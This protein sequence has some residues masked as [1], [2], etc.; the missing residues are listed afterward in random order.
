[1]ANPIIKVGLDISDIKQ[2]LLEI[3]KLTNKFNVPKA[4][5]KQVSLPATA[6]K[7]L[8]DTKEKTSLTK[9]AKDAEI[10]KQATLNALTEKGIKLNRQLASGRTTDRV[11]TSKEGKVLKSD[12]DALKTGSK[13]AVAKRIGRVGNLSPREQK[14][15]DDT[16]AQ[17]LRS[18]STEGVEPSKIPAL[19]QKKAA[20]ILRSTGT[21]DDILISNRPKPA[22]EP[23]LASSGATGAISAG[24]G[25][26]KIQET[27]RVL[28]KELILR[29]KSLLEVEQTLATSEEIQKLDVEIKSLKERYA[30]NLALG[31]VRDA[32][33][34]GTQDIKKQGSQEQRAVAAGIPIQSVGPNIVAAQDK[35]QQLE[36]GLATLSG[37]QLVA[38][39]KQLLQEYEIIKANAKI[40]GDKRLEA[41][42]GDQI[43]ALK[44]RQTAAARVAE[45]PARDLNA[46]QSRDAIAKSPEG[47]A[48]VKQRAKTDFA[49]GQ[50]SRLEKAKLAGTVPKDANIESVNKNYRNANARAKRATDKLEGISEKEIIAKN[51]S[52]VKTLEEGKLNAIILGKKKGAQVL[53]DQI[54]NAKG[55]ISSQQKIE[56]EQDRANKAADKAA[57]KA[58]KIPPKTSLEKARDEVSY[59]Q[60]PRG[61]QEQRLK[62]EASDVRKASRKQA[63]AEDSNT[64]TKPLGVFGRFTSKFGLNSQKDQSASKFFGSG[65]LTSL[66]YAI[67]SMALFGAASGISKSVVEAEQFKVELNKIQE[68]VD[69]TNWSKYGSDSKTAFAEIK[70]EIINISKET[71]LQLDIVASLTQQLIGAFASET[72]GN[73]SGLEL[74]K[75]Q[76]ESATKIAIATELAPKEITD[77]LTAASLSFGRTF[78]DIGNVAVALER[79][80]GVLGRE[81]IA[82]IGDI[83]PVAKEAGFSLEEFSALAATAQQRSGKSGAALAENFGRIIPAISENKDKLLELA[84]ASDA[85]RTPEFINAVNNSDIQGTLTTIA[86]EYE[87]LNAKSKQFVVSLLGGKREAQ[88]LIPALANNEVLERLTQAAEDSSGSLETRYQKILSSLTISVKALVQQMHVLAMEFLDSG[89]TAGLQA[90]IGAAKGL[91]FSLSGALKIVGSIN[92]VLQGF[93][94]IMLTFALIVKGIGGLGKKF[95]PGS[96][97]SIRGLTGGAGRGLA[98]G[99]AS[100]GLTAAKNA[101]AAATERLTLANQALMAATFE[102]GITGQALAAIEVEATAAKEAHR[103]ATQNLTLAEGQLTAT[104]VTGAAASAPVLAAKQALALAEVEH[105]AALQAAQVAEASGAA[106]DTLVIQANARVVASTEA[107]IAAEVAYTEALNLSGAAQVKGAATATLAAPTAASRGAAVGSGFLR[108]IGGGSVG[109]GAGVAVAAIFASVWYGLSKKADSLAEEAKEIAKIEQEATKKILESFKGNPVELAAA[110]ETRIDVLKELKRKAKSKEGIVSQ[111]VSGAKGIFGDAPSSEAQLIQD[112]IN[113]LSVSPQKALAIKLLK[114]GN[115]AYNINTFKPELGKPTGDF[116]FKIKELIAVSGNR[117]NDGVKDFEK[118]GDTKILNRNTISTSFDKEEKAYL[119]KLADFLGLNDPSELT[120]QI[121]K[122]ALQDR[123]DFIQQVTS[124]ADTGLLIGKDGKKG[125]RVDDKGTI[126][127]AN[128]II[129][130]FESRQAGGASQGDINQ[131]IEVEYQKIFGKAASVKADATLTELKSL[132]DSGGISRNQFI[133]GYLIQIENFKDVVKKGGSVDDKFLATLREAQKTVSEEVSKTVSSQ[134]S[135]AKRS[136]S[137]SGNNDIKRQQQILKSIVSGLGTDNI[138]ADLAGE[139]A[140]EYVDIQKSIMDTRIKNAYTAQQAVD[141]ANSRIDIPVS[142]QLG[143]LKSSL[144][145][146]TGSYEAFNLAF[147]A[148]SGETADMFLES[149]LNQIDSGQITVKQ[150]RDQLIEKMNVLAIEKARL[151]TLAPAGTDPADLA[152]S[153]NPVD[154][155]AAPDIPTPGNLKDPKNGLERMINGVLYRYN[156]KSRKWEI[157]SK[158]S[159]QT[160]RTSGMFSTPGKVVDYESKQAITSKD[161]AALGLPDPRPTNRRSAKPAKT[162]TAGPAPSASVRTPAEEAALANITLVIETI[163]QALGLD[164]FAKDAKDAANAATI[165]A[166]EATK[167]EAIKNLQ[168]ERQAQ[169]GLFAAMQTFN[170]DIVASAETNVIAAQEAVANA[171]NVSELAAAQSSL[172]SAQKALEDANNIQREAQFALFSAIIAK[173]DPIAQANISLV[174]AKQQATEARG[175]AAQADAARRVIEIQ[176]ELTDAMNAARISQFDLRQAELTA[177]GDEVGAAQVAAQSTRQQL[178]DTIAAGAGVAAINQARAATISADKAARDAV[179]S[180]KMDDYKFLL[181]MGQIT[182]SQY[183]NYL[184]GLKTT[185]I[186]GTKQFKD[187][188]L[189]IKQL[190]NDIGSDLQQNLP[191]SL[192]LPTLYEVRRLDQVSQTRDAAGRAGIGY[193]D[194]RTQDIKIYVN[195]GMGESEVVE[196]LSQALGTG[197][198]G[199]GPRRY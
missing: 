10:E 18:V 127:L 39:E 13:T 73:K 35:A 118:S 69:A 148:I 16:F 184:E 2:K 109:I 84:V 4:S 117:N 198:S 177:M 31:V 132:L 136:Q 79:S 154:F 25:I 97:T 81:T 23:P 174:L 103:L 82:F 89:L 104:R 90:A 53:D 6:Q 72:I 52:L 153:L 143:L 122:L 46:A 173:N 60:S 7:K 172:I 121:V 158:Q 74:V 88:A 108:L 50:L 44:S 28:E 55:R 41:A 129:K 91:V 38:A 100:A 76:V 71:G 175:I 8:L 37:E 42:A 111:L 15:Y 192:A 128:N 9:S 33:F 131:L 24:G 102:L 176:K 36:Q 119:K 120:G 161:A 159:M 130:N 191:T 168:A 140:L 142:A 106:N 164:T 181:D 190:K 182:K 116:E 186:P 87:N 180:D 58:E 155:I 156:A 185:L 183:A 144:Q 199:S 51:E 188:E 66:K 165:A 68:Q 80:S 1:M 48:A 170:G 134:I 61:Q 11:S 146:L 167:K 149:I 3:E 34:V 95:L 40:L 92:K 124:I 189:T 98:G 195:N 99:G 107:K 45:A 22:P 145:Q 163:F 151:S 96:L 14:L 105:L 157:I 78:E 115:L 29:R 152:P 26:K 65:A 54:N 47:Q 110:K 126:Q 123:Q 171:T 56:Q 193:Q 135:I 63:K 137:F 114:S 178:A 194:N 125:D 133:K 147:L 19:F 43:R 77:G 62:Q 27:E 112:Q 196:V 5:K 20:P 30:A 141:I 113:E 70:S 197:R 138:S 57:A 101:E 32:R 59:A 17:T 83:A 169:F 67:P 187:L 12:L 93:P 166:D 75:S 150:G 64:N 94:G 160:G 139:L 86:K 21:R 162:V 179:F 49:T 85:L